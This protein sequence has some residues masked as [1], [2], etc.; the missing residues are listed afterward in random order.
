[1]KLE[2]IV[3]FLGPEI[4][5][6]ADAISD[7]RSKLTKEFGSEPE[8]HSFYAGETET[9]EIVSVL[10]NASL[11]SDA[12]LILIKN[13]EQLKKKEDIE[14][15][16]GYIKAPEENT[17]LILISDEI[18]IDKT[19]E[20]AVTANA[21]KIF[22][23]LFENRKQQW[24]RAYFTRAGYSID[25]DAI[26]NILE[27]VENNTEALRRECSHL[28]LFTKDTKHIS[29][30]LVEQCL[31]HT[32]E[33]SAFTL[34][35]RICEGNPTKSLETLHTLLSAKQSP[36]AIFAGLSWCF[37]KLADYLRLKESGIIND[38]ELKK[39]DSV[40]KKHLRIT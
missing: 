22:W 25:E 20:S 36:Q 31:S 32:R 4:G 26:E 5:E 28:L 10:R 8:T 13:A 39:L 6:K 23:E 19:I 37:R 16:T 33:E 9:T 24:I 21:K 11:F 38:F 2:R 14:L 30:E 34:F 40:Q 18:S 17:S 15:L 1:M 27:L 12:R 35:S 29:A 3:L 7:I